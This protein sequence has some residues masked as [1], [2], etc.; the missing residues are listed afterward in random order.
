[1]IEINISD[2]P[3]AIV[4]DLERY[5][6]DVSRQIDEAVVEC[7]GIAEEIIISD[8]PVRQP[9]YTP[10]SGVRRDRNNNPLKENLQPGAYK[11]GWIKVVKRYDNGRTQG[12]VRNKTNYQLTHLLELGHKGKN[13]A[14][15][16]SAAPIPHITENEYEAREKL[17]EMITRILGDD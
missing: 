11:K 13:G 15:K 9:K 1:V 8:S 16:G 7:T 5:T 4:N 3:E 6:E 14:T 17:D 10:Q 12:Y 2:I